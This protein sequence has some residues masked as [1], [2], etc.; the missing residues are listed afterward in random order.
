MG[1]TLAFA[2]GPLASE[3]ISLLWPEKY[4]LAEQYIIWL[5]PAGA[6]STVVIVLYYEVVARAFEQKA[7]VIGFGVSLVHATAN[8]FLIQKFG[9]IGAVCGMALLSVMSLG[10]YAVLVHRYK[11]W[12]GSRLG[13]ILAY[14]AL[15]AAI[16]LIFTKMN[17]GGWAHFFSMTGIGV[18]LGALLLLDKEEKVVLLGSFSLR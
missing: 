16:W 18:S 5:L 9:A 15:M 2:C 12:E 13:W 6:I 1:V 14:V 3:L 4:L 10:S 8:W 7:L 17:V 11:F